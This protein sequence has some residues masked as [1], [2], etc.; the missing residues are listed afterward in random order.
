M[1][2]ETEDPDSQKQGD[3]CERYS[4]ANRSLNLKLKLAT[5]SALLRRERSQGTRSGGA[6]YR[7]CVDFIFGLSR[8]RFRSPT[9]VTACLSRNSLSRPQR[10]SGVNED[11][12]SG[13]DGWQP[14]SPPSASGRGNQPAG[15]LPEFNRGCPGPKDH[16]R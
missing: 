11:E 13:A 14:K 2:L 1:C 15:R 12:F 10:C 3:L 7:I 6:L 8:S 5:G 16:M 4:W 9:T